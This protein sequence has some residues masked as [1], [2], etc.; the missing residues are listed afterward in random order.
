MNRWKYLGETV[1]WIEGHLGKD[2]LTLKA[3]AGHARCS[4]YHFSR[5]FRDHCGLSVV[6]YVRK[7]SLV[8][9]AGALHGCGNVIDIALRFGYRSQSAF[10]R[11]FHRAFGVSP[12]AYR[13]SIGRLRS[14]NPGKAIELRTVENEETLRLVHDFG[15]L[16][17]N[18]TALGRTVYNGKFW[19]EQLRRNPHLLLYAQQRGEIVGAVFGWVGQDNNVTVG[20]AAVGE[21][22]RRHG[23]GKSLVDE[24]AGRARAAGHRTI[25]LG[26]EKGTERFYL[27]CGFRPTLFVQSKKHSLPELRALNT[28]YR[29]LWA[30]ESDANGWAKLM[31]STPHIDE[32]L[33]ET[34]ATSFEDCVPQTVFVKNL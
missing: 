3:V 26:A 16:I 34:Y 18:Y 23:I 12:T 19:T 20:L 6:A 17:L 30:V 28:R 15:D 22:H 33:Q 13:A 8:H 32:D 10:A 11:A 7:R 27:A 25:A 14:A 24:L 1:R 2:N 31:L 5:V 29:E 9:A 4:P 21:A